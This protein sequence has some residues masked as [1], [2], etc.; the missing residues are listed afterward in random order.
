MARQK[1]SREFN[2][3]G[4]P[5]GVDKSLKEIIDSLNG[6]TKSTT[7]KFKDLDRQNDD[8][9]QQFLGIRK[10]RLDPL[11]GDSKTLRD[12]VKKLQQRCANLEPQV[13]KL[14]T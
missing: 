14:G 11:E 13:K 12:A 2:L 10:A 7:E 8:K 1:F 5:A 4:Q 9:G 6:W 3:D